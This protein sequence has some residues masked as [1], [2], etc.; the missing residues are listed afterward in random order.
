MRQDGCR[1]GDRKRYGVGITGTRRLLDQVVAR[2]QLGRQPGRTSRHR[3][4]IWL[5][6]GTQC[7]VPSGPL[8][9]EAA[10]PR[11]RGS[12]SGTVPPFSR[13]PSRE[14]TLEVHRDNCQGAFHRVVRHRGRRRQ[15]VLDVEK[16]GPCGGDPFN[17]NFK[18][19]VPLMAQAT[20]RNV[21][22]GSK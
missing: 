18:D 21:K 13:Q 4:R 10:V 22:R 17:D 16:C 19:S 12:D 15:P 9:H 8:T 11:R 6:D 7:I 5:P 20:V 2:I 1:A 14:R 3:L